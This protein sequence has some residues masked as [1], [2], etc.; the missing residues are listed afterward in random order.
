MAS[1][2]DRAAGLDHDPDQQMLTCC[3]DE[4][5]PEQ[6][7]REAVRGADVFVGIVGFRYGSA[8]RDCPELSYTEV[9]SRRRARRACPV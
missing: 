3:A 9:G 7:C 2:V 1:L 6:V 8:V 4:R 5:P